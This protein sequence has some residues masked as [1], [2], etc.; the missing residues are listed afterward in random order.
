MIKTGVIVWAMCFALI[1]WLSWEPAPE[2][3][4]FLVDGQ[5][6]SAGPSCI[7]AWSYVSD[8]WREIACRKVR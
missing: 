7:A 2:H 6:V 3:W 1:Q 8:D 5:V 4:E